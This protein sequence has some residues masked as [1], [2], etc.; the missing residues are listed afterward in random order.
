MPVRLNTA[1][2]ASGIA[3]CSPIVSATITPAKRASGNAATMRARTFSR[4]RCT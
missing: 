1:H 2:C 3:R 4:A